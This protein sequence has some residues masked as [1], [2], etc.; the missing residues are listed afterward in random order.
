MVTTKTYPDSVDFSFGR[1]PITSE[2]KV[3]LD[4]NIVQARVLA[5][6]VGMG[7]SRA[8]IIHFLE[9]PASRVGAIRGV[10][11]IFMKAGFSLVYTMGPWW[12]FL[13]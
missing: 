12:E 10:K 8:G 3:G 13:Q 5:N 1:P 9:S 6:S 7:E 2:V 4:L 11:D